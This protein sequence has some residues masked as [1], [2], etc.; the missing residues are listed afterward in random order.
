MIAVGENEAVKRE[1]EVMK[2]RAS[3]IEGPKAELLE[4]IK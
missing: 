3:Q 1:N 2:R 4:S